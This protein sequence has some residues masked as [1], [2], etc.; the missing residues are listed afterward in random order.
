LFRGQKSFATHPLCV[1]KTSCDGGGFGRRLMNDY[2]VEAAWIART[3]GAPV[4]LLWNRADD[5][6]H[7]F[8][9]PAGW[10]FLKGGLDQAGRL[11]A[12]QQH[13]VS[14]GSNGAF[15]RS[16]NLDADTYPAGRVPNLSYGYSLIP[17]GIPTGS[18]RAP[19]DNALAFVFQSFID[20]MAHAASMM[21][22]SFFVSKSSA[23]RIAE[24]LSTGTTTAPWRSAWMRSPFFTAMPCTVTSPPKSTTCTKACEGA[25]EP[26]RS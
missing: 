14:F 4:K 18:L 19:G 9:R 6:Q 8:Y 11:V 17:F 2:M 22:A 26:A 25:I 13:F 3:A 12:W 21:R 16:A 10:H 23:P 1:P 24:I 20:E 15:A 5:M 7:D